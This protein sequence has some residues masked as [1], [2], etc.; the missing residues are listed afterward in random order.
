MGFTIKKSNGKQQEPFPAGAHPAVCYMLADLGRQYNAKYDKTLHKV[1]I[2][3]QFPEITGKRGDGTEYRRNLSK[4][5]TVSLHE[6]STMRAMLESW[7]GKKFTEE[8]LAAFDLKD[9]LGK[10]CLVNVTTTE[11]KGEER[12]EISSVG[13]LPK[14][15]Q[16][17]YKL[18]GEIVYYSMEDNGMDI[19]E[20]LPE[21]IK[22]AIS[23]SIEFKEARENAGQ[24]ADDLP[25]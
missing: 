14:A 25:Y 17:M 1:V 19:P 12:A 18:E 21:W 3:F 7:R 11:Y 5:Y 10:A 23:E 22:N 8:E 2:G 15:M 9:I 13:P 4:R 20:S 24:M 16:N 6:K